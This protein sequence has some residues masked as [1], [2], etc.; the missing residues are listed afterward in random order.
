MATTQVS[1]TN[2]RNVSSPADETR[3]FENDAIQTMSCQLHKVLSGTHK[4]IEVGDKDCLKKI[5]AEMV[6]HRLDDPTLT[7]TEV[8]TPRPFFWW[9]RMRRFNRVVRSNTF[10]AY[11]GYYLNYLSDLA[12]TRWDDIENST[13]VL[14]YDIYHDI[15]VVSFIM[16]T[17]REQIMKGAFGETGKLSTHVNLPKYS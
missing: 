2:S 10:D 13:S 12:K 3:Q 4:D 9:N 16:K 1:K 6:K 5:I 7:K 17:P 11:A 8:N 14:M 15:D